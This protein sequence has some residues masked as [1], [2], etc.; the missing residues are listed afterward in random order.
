MTRQRLPEYDEAVS[1][2]AGPRLVVPAEWGDPNGHLNVRHYLGQYD[3]TEWHVFDRVDLGETY[4]RSEQRGIFAL[5][6]HLVYGAEVAVGDS[7]SAH[8]RV[9]DLD[10]RMLHLVTYL[11]NH[12]RREAA[13]SLEALNA[14]VD[15]TSRRLIPFPDRQRAALEE[16]LRH[17]QAM[18]W[19]PGL[20]GVVKIR[21]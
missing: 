16:M 13:G 20:C 15:L 21:R 4:A 1:V 18:P 2:R 10:S 6:H 3:D 17:D 12:S 7:V 11:V 9:V 8:L 19:S 5:E 14:H